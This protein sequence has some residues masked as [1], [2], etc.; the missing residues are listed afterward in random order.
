MALMS[1]NEIAAHLLVTGLTALAIGIYL[2]S[3]R[4]ST[5]FWMLGMP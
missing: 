3:L 4:G 5:T 2:T 1:R